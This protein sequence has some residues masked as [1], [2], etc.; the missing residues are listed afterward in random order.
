MSKELKTMAKMHSQES[1]HWT[2]MSKAF[3]EM[4]ANCSEMHKEAMGDGE[5]SGHAKNASCCTKM[6]KMASAHATWHSERAEQCAKAASDELEKRGDS[7]VP[8]GI[9]RVTPDMPSVRAVP[10]AGQRT[11]A[12]VPVAPQFQ[13][14]LETEDGEEQS[15]LSR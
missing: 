4:A 1:A 11:P 8:D 9:S 2:G 3:G 13:K 5:E 10:R 14:F 15:L 6:Q 7:I 12:A